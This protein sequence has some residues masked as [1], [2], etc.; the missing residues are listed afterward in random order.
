[1]LNHLILWLFKKLMFA[2][3]MF[4]TD[5]LYNEID[6]TN[7]ESVRKNVV[8]DNLFVDTPFQAK[9]RASGVMDPFLGGSG[10]FEGFIYGRV[11][12]AAVAP[13]STVTVTRQ[14]LN[15]GMKFLPKA[16]VAWAPIDDWELDEGSGTGGVV[17][18]GPSL[19][20]NQYQILMEN[21]TMMINT[22]LEMDS[23]RHGQ[24]T[25]TGVTDNRVLNSNGLDE[26]LNNGID[27][28]P[29]GNIYP[30][31]GGDT[32]NGVIGP[33]LNSTPLWLGQPNA[34][35]TAANAATTINAAGQIDFNALMRLWAQCIVTGGKPD[36]GITNVFGFAAVANALD[37]QRRD[38]SN[39]KHDISW[40]GF[41]FNGVDIYP[42]PLAPSALA[43][44]FLS[45][46]PTAG[47]AGNNNLI[48]GA[49]GNSQTA[50]IVTPQFT[51]AGANVALSP[52]GSGF[53][54]NS[55]CTVG[56]VLYFLE[57]GSFKLRPTDK[58]GWNFGL[59]RSPMP[60]NVSMDALF[61]RL[62]TN[63]YNV[64]PRHSALAL[65]FSS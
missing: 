26:A 2:G 63:L 29:F 46:S 65:G 27:P 44:S 51:N 8:F 34:G 53:P 21:M 9:L 52:T 49:G 17:N 57:S 48:D 55:T 28:S 31:Y 30:T 3:T 18:S 32:R 56:E 22:M 11:Q 4:L 23:F 41:T 42:D 6:A 58:K 16:Y 37:A 19:I 35:A 64:M 24:P 1:M 25:G 61:M 36:L 12:G 40:D 60:N 47:K 10:M 7:L 14:Q 38:V 45:L 13:G 20:A 54:S 15:T 50:T 59:R 5:P 43:Q 62:G 39:T 33:A